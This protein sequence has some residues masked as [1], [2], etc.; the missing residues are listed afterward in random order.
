MSHFPSR[1]EAVAALRAAA[2]L[3]E[4]MPFDTS[5]FADVET[6]NLT[7]EQLASAA[8]LPGR[9]EKDITGT[10]N[11]IFMLSQGIVELHADRDQVCVAV[12][13]GNKVTT[14]KIV[15]PAVYEDVEVDEVE[16]VCEPLLSKGAPDG[17]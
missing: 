9:W 4:T 14:K 3:I 7:A 1:T 11:D 10:D 2:D 13:T 16:W 15:T 17:K 8:R 12:P 5:W 6:Y